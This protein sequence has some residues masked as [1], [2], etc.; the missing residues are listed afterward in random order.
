MLKRKEKKARDL[1]ANLKVHHGQINNVERNTYRERLVAPAM[2]EANKLDAVKIFSQKLKEQ[3]ATDANNQATGQGNVALNIIMDME[4]DNEK[5]ALRKR[6]KFVG[7]NLQAL[8]NVEQVRSEGTE[9]RLGL[10]GGHDQA[11]ASPSR[12]R[13]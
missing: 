6:E 8:R 5:P 9:P 2:K 12:Q 4:E 11:A 7:D 13:Q 10:D 1:F 3:L